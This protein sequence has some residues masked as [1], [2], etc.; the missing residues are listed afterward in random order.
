L[1]LRNVGIE[2]PDP[3]QSELGVGKDAQVTL[4][5]VSVSADKDT[6][7]SVSSPAAA[8]AA[9]VDGSGHEVTSV[10]V[11]ANGSL[12]FGDFGIVLRG[13]TKALRPGMYVEMTFVFDHA[14]KGTLKVPVRA[15]R[16][17]VPRESFQPKPAE[18]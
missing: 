14:G 17:P 2:P 13:M 16:T 1:A 12:G 15:N 18:E 9:F 5:V 4:S 10:E 8:S 11:P 6:L 3:G 7:V